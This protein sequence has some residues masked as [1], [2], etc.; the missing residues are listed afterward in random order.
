MMCVLGVG[1]TDMLASAP[2][3][4]ANEA[5]QEQRGRGRGG[6]DEKYPPGAM[7]STRV[8]PPGVRGQR[9]TV[10]HSGRDLLMGEMTRDSCLPFQCRSTDVCTA[11]AGAI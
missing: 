7:A 10:A 11:K 4:G 6:H 2:E 1:R 9:G 8:G 5:R 3:R